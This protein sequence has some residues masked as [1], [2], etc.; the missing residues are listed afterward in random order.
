MAPM[1]YSLDQLNFSQPLLMGVLNIT[2][3]SFSDGGK[4]LNPDI[5]LKHALQ[6]FAEGAAV[7]DLGAESSR[8]GAVQISEQEELD[9][10]M[11][12]LQKIRSESS[13]LVSIDTT[14]S[15]VAREALKAGA[16]I[17]N[18]VS[19]LTEDEAMWQ[20]VKEFDCLFVAMHRLSKSNSMQNNPQYADVVEEVEAFFKNTIQK[21]Q[22]LGISK[23]K[24]IL[25]PGIGFG[26]TLE[27]NLSLLKAADR[28]LKLGYPVLYGTS[29]KSFIGQ[30]LNQPDP[31]QRL[32]G[33]L[34]TTAYLYQKGVRFFRVHDVQANADVIKVLKSC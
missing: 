3:D 22:N 33:T 28:F 21:S 23:N 8:P 26:K 16:N 17:I 27:H 19:G 13:G 31:E 14:K 5:A 6:M 29:R 10:L 1:A 15:N 18:D 24:L 25:D 12:V 7:I 4:F 34:A 30:L 2:P 11:P 9:R 20:V 32:S